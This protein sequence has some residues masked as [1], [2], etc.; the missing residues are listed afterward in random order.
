MADTDTI[1]IPLGRGKKTLLGAVALVVSSLAGVGAK[2][3]IDHEIQQNEKLDELLK[4]SSAWEALSEH[5][6][7]LRKIE[8]LSLTNEKLVEHILRAHTD[9]VVP[10]MKDVPLPKKPRATRRRT[11][12]DLRRGYEQRSKK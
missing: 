12:K 9:K 1:K 5:D 8:I 10:Q 6:D 11:P 3:M 7:R 4:A 2:A